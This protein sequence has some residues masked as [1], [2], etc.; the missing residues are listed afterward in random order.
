[1]KKGCFIKSVIIFTILLASVLY[2]IENKIED[3]VFEPGR[4]IVHSI[5]GNTWQ[6]NY[7]YIKNTPEKDSLKSLL[8]NYFDGKNPDEILSDE[9]TR[10]ILKYVEKTLTDSLIE[11][12]ELKEIKELIKQ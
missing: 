8:I 1:M 11:E 3:I 12:F 7:A 6:K 4:K 9:R 2:I 10:Y 5:I